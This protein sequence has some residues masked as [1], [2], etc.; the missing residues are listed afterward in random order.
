MREGETEETNKGREIEE[1]RKN[2][3]R[4]WEGGR[5]GESNRERESSER[6]RAGVNSLRIN[7]RHLYINKKLM[8]GINITCNGET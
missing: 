7:N 1:R 6:E 3:E 8:G 4:Q 5:E 2:I